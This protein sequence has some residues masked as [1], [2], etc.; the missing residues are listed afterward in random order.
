[1]NNKID[2]LGKANNILMSAGQKVAN[3]KNQP[4][5]VVFQ[6]GYNK[7]SNSYVGN[8]M[9]RF[10][11]VGIEAVHHRFEEDASLTEVTQ[12]IK[13][14]AN[15]GYYMLFQ[16]SIPGPL[17]KHTD[18][19][20]NTIPE[21]LDIDRL[22]HLAEAKVY[23]GDTSILPCTVQGVLDS[24]EGIELKG[25]RVLIVGRSNIVGKPLMHAML[26]K[27]ATVIVAHSRSDVDNLW[28]DI[29][30]EVDIVVLATGV[31]DLIKTFNES[32]HIVIDVG[33]SFDENGKLRGDAS[34]ENKMRALAYTSVPGGIGQLTTANVIMNVIKLHERVYPDGL[35]FGK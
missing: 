5:A 12:M 1:M 8:K 35:Y 26:A 15:M 24:L 3:M 7:D 14:Y 10:E 30:E 6:V 23:S 9:K 16:L 18:E 21:E 22:T 25:K 34:E 20:I 33:I 32:K 27:D 17:G 2:C 11:K 4:C 31:Q 28:W 29:A 13:Y 19:I